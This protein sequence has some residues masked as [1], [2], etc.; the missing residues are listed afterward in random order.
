[1]RESQY[2]HGDGLK[3]E[4]GSERDSASSLQFLF[5]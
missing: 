5:L 1:M 3:V 2:V 4:Y